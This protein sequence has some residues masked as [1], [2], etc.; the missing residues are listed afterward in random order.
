MFEKNGIYRYWR[1]Q[2]VRHIVR[3][4]G[5]IAFDCAYKRTSCECVGIAWSDCVCSWWMLATG[6]RNC[7]FERMVWVCGVRTGA[8]S[9]RASTVC[10]WARFVGVRCGYAFGRRCAYQR[11]SGAESLRPCGATRNVVSWPYEA[12]NPLMW[13]NSN[14][15]NAIALNSVTTH[16]NWSSVSEDHS[17][18]GWFVFTD[19]GLR[20]AVRVFELESH[21]GLAHLNTGC[22]RERANIGMRLCTRGRAFLNS[23]AIARV[24]KAYSDATHTQWGPRWCHR[25]NARDT[26][27]GVAM[28]LPTK[29]CSSARSGAPRC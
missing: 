6:R 4:Y 18:D 13:P 23:N 21:W 27:G 15:C 10:F 9:Q 14:Y 8:W 3:A 1:V 2:L 11:K 5:F 24:R 25:G 20:S 16:T 19:R 17:V 29:E 22:A 28:P 7:A 26:C 12:C